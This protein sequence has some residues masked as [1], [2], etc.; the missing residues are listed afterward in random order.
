MMVVL[1][2]PVWPTMATVCP[3]STRKET[4]RS[5]H[6]SSFGFGTAV[7]GEPDI[8][9]FDFAAQGVEQR[10]RVARRERW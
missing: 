6:S 4:S 1:P 5:T 10:F 2:A 8:A 3:G 7:I 9:E